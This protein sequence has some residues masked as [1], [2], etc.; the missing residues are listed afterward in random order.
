MQ[1]ETGTSV[2]T[3]NQPEIEVEKS[4]ILYAMTSYVLI[5]LGKS[6][7]YP[8]RVSALI[9]SILLEPERT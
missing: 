9:F 3:K 6:R 5:K 2:A 7:V 4:A 1:P 8:A